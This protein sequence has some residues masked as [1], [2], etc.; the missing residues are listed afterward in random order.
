MP[1]TSRPVQGIPSPLTPPVLQTQPLLARH[2]PPQVLPFQ[3]FAARVAETA[4]E[5]EVAEEQQAARRV[6]EESEEQAH[7]SHSATADELEQARQT[8]RLLE[9]GQVG[10]GA[11]SFTPTLTPPGGGCASQLTL[12]QPVPALPAS[13]TRAPWAATRER[14][15]QQAPVP[16]TPLLQPQGVG[17]VSSGLPSLSGVGSVPGVACP[18]YASPSPL[19]PHAC[20]YPNLQAPLPIAPHEEGKIDFKRE[21]SALPKLNLKGGDATSITRTI[22]EWLQRT[23][24][25]LNTWSASAVQLWHNA[26]ALAKAAHNQWTLMAPSQRALQ[27]GLPSTGHALL[28][29][30]SVLEAIM[31]SDLC[32]HC[33]PEKIQSLAIQKGANTVADLLYLTFQTY[34]PSEP[35][36]RVEGLATIEAPAKPARTFGEALSFIRSWRQQVLTVVNDLGGNPEPLKL[37]STLRTLISSLVASDTAFAMEVSQI[38]RQTNVKTLCNDVFLLTT[39]DLLEVELSSRAQE[40]EEER[41]KQK[42]ANAASASLVRR[43][44]DKENPS[45]FAET[46]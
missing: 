18:V 31:R 45:L 23:S 12:G 26:V 19:T 41:R 34:L 20:L 36:A 30:L 33:L 27:T 38:Y 32:N 15:Q 8:I 25:A 28:A 46:S 2:L 1:D 37:L 10:S 43:E 40:D 22:H 16:T 9:Q 44:E 3:D 17:S 39:V 4:L 11:T 29:Q 13:S 35:S 24:I 5:R 21:K 14:L 42:G 7:H 6:L